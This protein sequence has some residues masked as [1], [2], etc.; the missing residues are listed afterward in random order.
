MI[1]CA[2]R[3]SGPPAPRQESDSREEEPRTSRG[4]RGCGHCKTLGSQP[5][6]SPYLLCFV[7]RKARS[8]KHFIFLSALLV[9]VASSVRLETSA[10]LQAGTA[11]TAANRHQE[12]VTTYCIT[13]HSSRAKMGGL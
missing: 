6:G 12:M 7:I 8:M 10:T 5:V 2:S 1:E 9:L 4:S 11:Q 13:C 3:V